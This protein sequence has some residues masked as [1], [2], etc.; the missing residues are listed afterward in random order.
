MEYTVQSLLDAYGCSRAELAAKASA[1]AERCGMSPVSI[2][3][4]Y[5]WANRG[6]PKWAVVGFAADLAA[7]HKDTAA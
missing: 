4:L 7:K 5:V 2:G 6:L 3:T 1:I